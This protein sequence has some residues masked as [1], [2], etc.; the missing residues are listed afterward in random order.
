LTEELVYVQFSRLEDLVKLVSF[1]PS[2]FI[3]HLVVNDKHIYFVQSL[4]MISEPMVYI[5]R[6]K[7]KIEKKYIVYNRF[8]DEISFSDQPSQD[9]QSIYIPIL[10]VEK[11]NI[12]KHLS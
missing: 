6:T 3:Q 9:G 10:E 5:F 12:L 1:S 2:P 7:E 8:S 4:M 11:T